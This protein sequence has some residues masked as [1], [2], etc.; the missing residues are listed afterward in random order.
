LHQAELHNLDNNVPNPINQQK[1]NNMYLL[2]LIHNNASPTL[3]LS[4]QNGIRQQPK[5][6]PNMA[7]TPQPIHVTKPVLFSTRVT[8]IWLQL[9]QLVRIGASP[10]ITPGV[11]VNIVLLIGDACEL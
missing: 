7:I 3:R 2:F 9:G 8:M 11:P 5:H 6:P 10:Y 4:I 1:K